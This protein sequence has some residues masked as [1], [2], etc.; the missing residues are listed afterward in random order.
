MIPT[1]GSPLGTTARGRRLPQRPNRV[2][3]TETKEK[4]Q[5]GQLLEELLAR[6]PGKTMYEA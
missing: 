6:H 5:V 3:D 4:E 2:A 1:P